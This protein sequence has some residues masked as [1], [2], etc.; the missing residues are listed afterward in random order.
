MER[1]LK[2]YLVVAAILL[3]AFGA[4]IGYLLAIPDI[5][6][7]TINEIIKN[8]ACVERNNFNLSVGGIK[9]AGANKSNNNNS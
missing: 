5:Q 6:Q 9:I 4:S 2:A 7:E 1:K 3:V 8:Y